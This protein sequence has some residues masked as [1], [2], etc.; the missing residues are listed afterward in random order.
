MMKK[1]AVL[2]IAIPTFI[3]FASA[4]ESFLAKNDLVT[5]T[6]ADFAAEMARLPPEQQGALRAAPERLPG[7]I[8]GLLVMKTLAA[9]ARQ[10]KLDESPE[11]KA[12]IQAV[13]DRALAQRRLD[14]YDATLKAPDFHKR[15]R[16]LY[17]ADAKAYEEKPLYN[18]SHIMVDFKCRTPDAARARAEEA[19]KVLLGGIPL[20]DVVSQYSDD[21]TAANNKGSL[22]WRGYDALN[23]TLQELLPTM[24]KGQVSEPVSSNFGFHVVVLHDVKP[25][26]QR[27]FDEVKDNIIE[28]LRTDFVKQQRQKLVSEI[29]N[30]PKIQVNLHAITALATAAKPGSA[31][32]EAVSPALSGATPPTTQSPALAP[33]PSTP[34]P[35]SVPRK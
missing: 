28:G 10:A 15:A 8:E 16:E 29:T 3:S 7:F 31:P 20:A 32:G 21:P 33:V 30:D 24:K 27:S 11:A 14:Q 19:R 18:A 25:A 1:L 34:A 35:A 9:Q 17:L 4:E 23:P 6:K 12:E 22:G 5:V 26:R 13:V 2:L